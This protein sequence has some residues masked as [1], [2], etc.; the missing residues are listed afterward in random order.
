MATKKKAKASSQGSLFGAKAS[1]PKASA[2][3][4]SASKSKARPAVVTVNGYTRAWP[5]T[6]KK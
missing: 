4:A 3:K 6:K 2:P 5:G 1:A